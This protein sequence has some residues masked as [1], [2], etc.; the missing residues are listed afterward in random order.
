[1][2]S[3][4]PD[5]AWLAW[6]ARLMGG[7]SRQTCAATFPP[8]RFYCLLDELPL[9]LIP[10]W[11]GESLEKVVEEELFLN[12]ECRIAHGEQLPAHLGF[13]TELLTGFAP[14]GTVAWVRDPAT[15]S[16]L[17]FWLGPKLEAVVS[18]LR[19]GESA[20]DRLPEDVR[21]LLAAAGILTSQDH[22]DQ[23][24]GELQ[25]VVSNAAPAFRKKG[26]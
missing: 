1:M 11:V 7:A 2:A 4:V 10:R 5:T 20:S 12:P 9:H 3:Q 6:I 15:L 17:P 22:A 16:L 19:P 14:R 24:I 13:E 8:N 25:N 18:S 21:F 26:Y 23:R